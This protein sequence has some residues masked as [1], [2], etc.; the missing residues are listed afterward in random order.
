MTVRSFLVR[1]GSGGDQLGNP[2]TG[3]GFHGSNAAI[4]ALQLLAQIGSQFDQM[5]IWFIS[6]LEKT[7]SHFFE[8]QWHCE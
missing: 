1:G 7:I 5:I 2:T 6:K 3:A 4:H 8:N